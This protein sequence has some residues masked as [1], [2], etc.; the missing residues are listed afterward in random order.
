MCISLCRLGN[1]Y[2]SMLWSVIV[3]SRGNNSRGNDDRGK[4]VVPVSTLKID[5][6][7]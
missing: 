4:D 5:L 3:S 1:M 6:N 2:I 7:F